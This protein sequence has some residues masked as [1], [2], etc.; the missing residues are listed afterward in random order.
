MF[1]IFTIVCPV[2]KFSNSS[3]FFTTA[4]FRSELM[5]RVSMFST[6]TPFNDKDFDKKFRVPTYYYHRLLRWNISETLDVYPHKIPRVDYVKRK[7]GPLWR[8]PLSRS[9]VCFSLF[10]IVRLNNSLH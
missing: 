8:R 6:L 1:G 4:I 9:D 5:K 3:V 7:V 2:A 10:Q